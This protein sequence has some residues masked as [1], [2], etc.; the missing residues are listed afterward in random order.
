[1]HAAVDTLGDLLALQVTAA[2]EQERAQAEKL[3]KAVQQITGDRVE[4]AY[5]DQG[6]HRGSRRESGQPARHSTGGGQAHRG[7]TR[8]RPA[9][10]PRD[11]RAQLRLGRTLP[12]ARQRV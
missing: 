2:N 7:Q 1:V 12:K 4:L 8:L 6:L 9:A 10:A 5:V 3:A 11:R